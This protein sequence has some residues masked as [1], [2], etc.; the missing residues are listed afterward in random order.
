MSA[1]QLAEQRCKNRAAATR[2]EAQVAGAGISALETESDSSKELKQMLQLK[3]LKKE[4]LQLARKCNDEWHRIHVLSAG[5]GLLSDAATK[6]SVERIDDALAKLR[7]LE[8][9]HLPLQRRI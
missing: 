5:L 1:T 9:S 4:L 6:D 2:A 7:Q 3:Q 8:A